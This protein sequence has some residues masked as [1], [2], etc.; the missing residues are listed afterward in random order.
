MKADFNMLHLFNASL[1][2]GNTYGIGDLIKRRHSKTLRQNLSRWTS[3]KETASS[4]YQWQ[5]TQT[6]W[7]IGLCKSTCKMVKKLM[8]SPRT[9]KS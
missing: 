6:L 5:Y 8:K 1:D 4:C 3:S 2:F 9:N 7:Q